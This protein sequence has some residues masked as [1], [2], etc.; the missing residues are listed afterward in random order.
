VLLDGNTIIRVFKDTASPYNLVDTCVSVKPAAVA[1]ALRY[2][3]M[4]VQVPSNYQATRCHLREYSN[5]NIRRC[6]NLVW[7][8]TQ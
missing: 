3:R 5:I 7:N 6:I 4:E 1:A 8:G 2:I